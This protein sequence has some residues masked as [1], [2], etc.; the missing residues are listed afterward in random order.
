MNKNQ[1]NIR[2]CMDFC[3][4]NK[5]CPKY[6][7]STPLSDHILD[8]FARSKVFSFMDEFSGYNQIQIKPEDQ[9]KMTFIFPWGNFVR[10]LA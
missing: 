9:N 1:G 10:K 8:E 7:F 6:N 2:V 5:S 4:L 3:D